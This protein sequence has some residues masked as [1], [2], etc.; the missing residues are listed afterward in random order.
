MCYLEEN[1]VEAK[2]IF[3]KSVAAQRAREAAKKA[4]E[5]AR[6]KT[7]MES[8]SLP[9]KLADCSEHDT[10]MTEI[11]IV[12]GDSAGGSAKEGRDRRYQAILPLWGKMLNVEKARIDKVYGNEKL[13]PVVTALGT[14][15]GEDFDISKLRY[16][17]IIIMADADVDGSH[18]RTLLLT[19]FFR[20]MKPLITNGNIYIA[21]PPLFK[22]FRGKK[23]RYAFS[24]EERDEYIAE[25]TTENGTKPEVQRYKGLGEMDPEQLWETTMN[26]ETRTMLKIDMEDAVK[27]D[28]TFTILMGDKVAPRREFIEANAKY[29]ENLDI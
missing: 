19:F 18:I 15:I 27:A 3:E 1:P 5:T 6:R 21:Q 16:G 8:A 22:V 23:V 29:V 17:K 25:L 24:D 4:R 13:M 26:P 2:A 20:F 14:S 9:G 10:E 7:A 28:E 12:E 11:Y